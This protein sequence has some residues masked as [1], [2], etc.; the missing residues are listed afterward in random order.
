[1]S[2]VNNKKRR[3]FDNR[4]QRSASIATKLIQNPMGQR[5]Y[6]DKGN[7][8]ATPPPTSILNSMSQRTAQVGKDIESMKQLLPDIELSA[9]ILVSSILSPKDMTT[10]TLSFSSNSAF[11]NQDLGTKLT[12]IV[13]DYFTN[14]YRINTKLSRILHDALFDKGAHIRMIIP[15]SSLDHIINEQGRITLE[16]IRPHVDSTNGLTLSSLGLLGPSDDQIEEDNKAGVSFESM[17]SNTPRPTKVDTVEK[18]CYVSVTDNPDAVKMPLLFDRIRSDKVKS[19]LAGRFKGSLESKANNKDKDEDSKGKQSSEKLKKEERAKE[20]KINLGTNDKEIEQRLS[21]SR[22]LTAEPL[23]E[24]KTHEQTGRE[25]YGHPM[26]TTLSNEAV[27]PA[28]TPGN[29]SDHIGYFVLLDQYGNPVNMSSVT[30]HY[31]DL[32]TQFSGNTSDNQVSSLLKEIRGQQGM[33][34]QQDPTQAIQ[35][36]TDA[37]ADI[38]ERN[39]LSRLRNGIGHSSAELGRPSDIYQ[40]MLSRSFRKKRTQLLYVPKELMSYVAFNYTN[41]GVGKSLLEESRIVGSLRAILMFANTMA[42]IK[43]SSS[44]TDLEIE[45]DPEDTD[46]MSTITQ[47]KDAFMRSRSEAFPLG[48]G[49]PGVLV[50]YLNKSGV[51]VI[52]SGHPGLPEMRVQANDKAS[53][54]TIVDRDLEDQ[55]RRQHIMGFGLSPETVDVSGDVE[56]ATSLVNSSLLLNKRVA[57]YQQQYERM[58]SEFIRKYTANS[59]PLLSKMEKAIEEDGH[60]EDKEDLKATIEQFLESLEVSLPKPDSVTLETQMEAFRNYRDALDMAVEALINDEMEMLDAEGDFGRNLRNIKAT[61][62][63]YFERRWL[64][65]NNV[66]PELFEVIDHDIDDKP[67]LNFGEIHGSHM[68]RILDSMREYIAMAEKARMKREAE[69]GPEEGAE[70]TPPADDS[71]GG[72]F[73]DD[74]DADS[75]SDDSDGTGGDGGSD[76]GLGDWL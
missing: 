68:E 20:K 28:H 56:F 14:D 29:P 48:E 62:K 3:G 22:D 61:I 7:R 53:S 25:M 24:V 15:E 37:F 10:P 42:A 72:G 52:Y 64:R 44:R 47:V 26:I 32:K 19:T 6:D 70:S 69:Q 33:E 75:T 31:Q 49:N 5:A 12:K 11:G 21:D 59:E 38:I 35:Q 65:D 67:L 17:F 50:D 23:V 73:G 36:A 51:D 60:K 4:Q 2:D 58:E 39:L 30:D 55:L 13:S 66:L 43:N 74:A 1:M 71:T 41:T 63:A 8:K 40:I 46:P 54:R 27:I 57:L 45:L 34:F 18:T 16:S 76:D 9:Q